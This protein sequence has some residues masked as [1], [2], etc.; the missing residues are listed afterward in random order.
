MSIPVIIFGVTGRMGSTLLRMV[1]ED[2]AFTLV[3]AVDRKEKLVEAKKLGCDA[4]ANISELLQVTPTATIIDFTT[5]EGSLAT[6]QAAAQSGARH[7]I[8]TTGFT[9]EQKEQLAQIACKTPV[10]W[11]PNMSIGVNVLLSILPEVTKKLGDAYNV[12]IVELHHNRKK[13]APSGTALRLAE[14]VADAKEWKLSETACYHREGII[15]ERPHKE[16]GVQTVRGGDVV[17]VHTVYFM[18]PGERIEITHQ[19]HSRD[20]FAEGALRAVKWIQTQSAG[21]LYTMQDVL[22]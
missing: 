4:V 21:K 9:E 5:P 6:A 19:A 18:G 15:G 16:I 22:Q 14:C 11:S 1:R 10:F 3:G 2:S 7:I 20:N 17:G 12:E 13:D 8:G